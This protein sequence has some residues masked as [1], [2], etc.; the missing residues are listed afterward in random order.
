MKTKSPNAR[1]HFW[2]TVSVPVDGCLIWPLAKDAKGYG[3]CTLFEYG[4]SQKIHVAA[5]VLANGPKPEKTEAGHVCG[6]SSCYNPKHLR[7]VTRSENQL[8]RRQ[9]GTSNSQIERRLQR[10]SPARRMF[11]VASLAAG[12]LKQRE[13]AKLADCCFTTV[14]KAA[15]RER[16]QA[17]WRALDQLRPDIYPVPP[18]RRATD[19]RKAGAQ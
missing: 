4:I 15:R 3:I 12:V 17:E 18:M 5:C 1:E 6:N 11:I 8:Q 2:A 9:H 13:I 19:R 14:S 10:L 7:W 16:L